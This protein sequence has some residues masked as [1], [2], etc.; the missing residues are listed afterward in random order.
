MTK[1]NAKPGKPG[2]VGPALIAFG[3]TEDGKPRAGTFHAADI[4]LAT[5]AAAAMGLAIL[6]L[7]DPKARDLATQIPG[8]QVHAKGR[9]FVP[10]IRQAQYAQLTEFAKAQGVIIQDGLAGEIKNSKTPATPD[11][12]SDREPHLPNSWDHIDVGALVLAQDTD[13][14]DGWWQAVVVAKNGE[15]YTLRWQQS[16]TRRVII[17]H[18][19]NLAL[20]WPGNDPNIKPLEVKD[21]AAI[22]PVSWQAIGLNQVVLAKEEGPMEQWW[23]AHPIE[24]STDTFTLKWRD[25]PALPTIVRPRAALA[26]VHPNP[27]A[28]SAK[29][30]AAA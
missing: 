11:N 16:Q 18:K 9:G 27:G 10:L 30:T 26:L 25:Y 19:F 4:E 13:P 22:Y 28:V 20:L 2:R 8:G 17:K 12:K 24:V 7:K 14:K 23:E 6:K 21:T 1:K 15:M 3:L 5:K 29:S